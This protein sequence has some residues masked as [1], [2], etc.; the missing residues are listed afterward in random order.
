MTIKSFVSVQTQDFDLSSEV[1]QLRQQSLQIGAVASF[2]GLVR[3]VNE[4]Q[5]V[6]TMELEHYAGMTERSIED[7]IQ[8]AATRWELIGARVIH[9]IGRLAPSDQI[10]LSGQMNKT[11]VK[12]R[13]IF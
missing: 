1:N 5:Q 13:F 11:S 2:V 6:A 7:I 9:R 10:V 3:D 8:Q 4:G 12:I